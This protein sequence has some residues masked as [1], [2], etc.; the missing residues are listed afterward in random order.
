MSTTKS[1]VARLSGMSRVAVLGTG[2][3]G[4]TTA[5][6]L[7]HL[8]HKVKA[9]DR[10]LSKLDSLG[11]GELPI[12][13]PGLE[14]FL[15]QTLASGALQISGNLAESLIDAEFVYICVPTPAAEDG[16]ADIRFVLDAV[17]EVAPYLTEGSVIVTKSTVPVGSS[18][19]IEAKL[20]RNDVD[21]ASNPEFLREGSAVY[22]FLNPDRI[23]VGASNYSVAQKIAS[24]YSS[25]NSKVIITDPNSAELIKYA[26]NSFLAIKL[27]FI[28]EM[29]RLCE[30]VGADINDVMTGFGTDARIG[31][32][33][34]SPGPGWGGSCF[35]KDTAA[36]RSLGKEN[37]IELQ[38]ID[39]ALN[40]NLSTKRHVVS[41]LRK[42]LGGELSGKRI[43]VL[44]LTFKA[45]TDD[46]RDSPALEIANELVNLGANVIAFDPQVDTSISLGFELADSVQTAASH[47][48]ALLVL[49]EWPEF[50]EIEPQEILER[51]SGNLV[52]DTRDVLTEKAWKDSGATFIRTGKK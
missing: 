37:Q 3:V 20:N 42:N 28:N 48:D 43:T 35:P 8:G 33:F 10:D 2:Y 16:S 24:L 17:S 47:A 34:T 4:A 21:V 14:D 15:R 7:A 13:E 9:F 5:I 22:D 1:L 38:M 50:E 39:A 45:N 6:M 30:A 41:R 25:L 52:F 49:T 29:A 44:G 27:S 36:L 12:Y 11:R 46:L 18:E 19:K 32:K 40:S 51:M 23:V 31:Q 26:S